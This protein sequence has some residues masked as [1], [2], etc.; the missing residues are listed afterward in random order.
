EYG[1]GRNRDKRMQA[2]VPAEVR[3]YATAVDA[4]AE[5]EH[6]LGEHGGVQRA[7]QEEEEERE[8]ERAVLDRWQ[9]AGKEDVDREARAR[10]ER[11]VEHREGA[12]AEPAPRSA[13]RA[14]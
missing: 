1:S 14:A 9:P 2:D 13:E 10:E 11:L 5:D 6:R 12:R 8:R 3:A 7:E 4:R